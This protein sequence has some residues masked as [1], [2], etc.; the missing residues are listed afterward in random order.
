MRGSRSQASTEQLLGSFGAGNLILLCLD[1]EL[2]KFLITGLICIRHIARAGLR[3]FQC[4]IKDA[5]Q[6]IVRIGG[7]CRCL[8][9]RTAKTCLRRIGWVL[10]VLWFLVV[11]HSI[12]P[13]Y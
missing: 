3:A 11:L 2:R 8:L 13:A 1:E 12:P 10:T 7:I 4:V 5:D 6:I 9:L